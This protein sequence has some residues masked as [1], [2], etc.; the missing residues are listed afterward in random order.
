MSDAARAAGLQEM[1]KFLGILS[2]DDL[3]DA[4]RDDGAALADCITSDAC[5]RAALAAAADFD[6]AATGGAAAAGSTVDVGTQTMAC[7]AEANTA[8]HGT[9]RRSASCMA[10]P[11]VA[12]QFT[13]TRRCLYGTSTAAQTD[14]S[15]LA[16]ACR[17]AV[18]L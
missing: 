10:K 5:R 18:V 7:T 17:A 11:V 3:A 8:T 2:V 1:L 15:A 16:M 4:I 12:S 6:E 9:G 13:Q 14:G